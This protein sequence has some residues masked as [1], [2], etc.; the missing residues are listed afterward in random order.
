MI[1]PSPTSK[2]DP[3][4][5][6]GVHAQAPRPNAEGVSILALALPNTSYVLHL[7]AAEP[8]GVAVGKRVVGTIRAEVRRLDVVDTGGR[9]LEPVVGR[10]RRVQGRV[11]RAGGGVV[12]VD[13]GVAVHCVLTD[14]RQKAE[15]F[16][17]GQVVSC[18]VRDGATF[19]PR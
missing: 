9:Y 14:E 4:L 2:I 3:T 10:P 17:P 7:V 18:D 16:Q 12:V 13:A 1:T 6:R 5:A 8:V 19:T 15:D 11:I